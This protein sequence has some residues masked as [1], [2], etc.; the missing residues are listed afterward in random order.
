[1]VSRAGVAARAADFKA[2]LFETH[3]LVNESLRTAV[4]QLRIAR[5]K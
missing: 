1:M 5:C 4:K 2:K 3:L